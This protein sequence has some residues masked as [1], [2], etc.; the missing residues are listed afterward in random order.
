MLS[1][2]QQRIMGYFIEEAKDHLNTI[3]QGLINL[4]ATIEDSEMVHEVFR[5]AH[6]VKGGAAMLGLTS[7]QHAAH[8]LEDYFKVLKECPGVRT[9]HKLET[10]FLRVFDTLQ[11]LIE[12]LQGPFGLTED[13]AAE[14]MAAVEPVFAELNQ[15][16]TALVSQ[17]GATLP[18][19]VEFVAS[20]APA[21]PAAPVVSK[22]QPVMPQ[23]ESAVQLIFRS[24]VPALLR[25]MLQTFKQ[26]DNA[27]TRQRLQDLCGQ[28]AQ[29]GEQLDIPYWCDLLEAVKRS[30]AY[31]ENSYR[32]LAPVVIKELK[33]AQDL[34]LSGQAIEIAPSDSL[35]DLLPQLDW[36]SGQDSGESVESD[37]SSWFDSDEDAPL[38]TN[39]DLL[40]LES[41]GEFALSLEESIAVP[42][43]E[44]PLQGTDAEGGD[45]LGDLFAQNAAANGDSDESDFFLLD[46][47]E[48]EAAVE[49]SGPGVG[50]A[51]LNSL[52]DLFEANLDAGTSSELS[53]LDSLDGSFD[54][55]MSEMDTA[56]E[57][58][59]RAHV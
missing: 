8:R 55:S 18:D 4:Q 9:T 46:L 32:I 31:P 33:Q 13:K 19:D 48:P 15:D 37:L 23:E 27:N 10:L 11:A 40:G 44:L 59:G 25:Q 7:I 56:L 52:A 54:S 14:L 22:P 45:L 36:G 38:L 49:R 20:P 12:Q 34:V 5:A 57:E 42:E 1:E 47:G 16:L 24:D 58:I 50:D 17:T 41:E 3:E 35:L 2:Q 6:S 51:E 43:M 39:S 30:I 21:A 26:S 29:P 53:W 28:L